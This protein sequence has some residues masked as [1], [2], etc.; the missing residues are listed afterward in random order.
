MKKVIILLFFC[1]FFVIAQDVLIHVPE[2]N[3][4]EKRSNLHQIGSQ[5]WTI[6]TIL[7]KN[8]TPYQI[9]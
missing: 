9:F 4:T 2:V 3:F 7:T 1:P 5:Q 6:D 8:S